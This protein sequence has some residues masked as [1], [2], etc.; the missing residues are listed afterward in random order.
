MNV[1]TN[2]WVKPDV[3]IENLIKVLRIDK[4]A[5]PYVKKLLEEPQDRSNVLLE[6]RNLLKDLHKEYVDSIGNTERLHFDQS[7]TDMATSKLN[8][9]TENLLWFL[10]DHSDETIEYYDGLFF[11]WSYIESYLNASPTLLHV[12]TV[13]KIY[14]AP[15]M[16]FLGPV[17]SSFVPIIA[18]KW[19]GL[20]ISYS[21]A[22]KIVWTGLTYQIR[23]AVNAITNGKNPLIIAA[24]GL[25][26][27][28][29]LWGIWTT[30]QTSMEKYAVLA[31]IRERI[32][33]LRNFLS[34]LKIILHDKRNKYFLNYKIIAEVDVLLEALSSNSIGKDLAIFRQLFSANRSVNNS[35]SLPVQSG[36][37]NT[38]N[39]LLVRL[40]CIIDYAREISG[41]LCIARLLRIPGYCLPSW[42]SNQT[43]VIDVRGLCHPSLNDPVPNDIRL[44]RNLLITGPNQAGKST[45]MRSLLL[46]VWMSQTIG[47]VRA[48]SFDAT[49][50]ELIYS[51]IGLTDE[52]GRESLFQAEMN[53]VYEYLNHIKEQKDLKKRHSICFFD[54]LFTSTNHEEGV[55]AALA[56]S[57][58]LEQYPNALTII[59]S[60][61]T[62]LKNL[63]FDKVCLGITTQQGED[64]LEKLKFTYK[65]QPGISHHR[66]ALKL[67]KDKGYNPT[68]V[69]KAYENLEKLFSKSTIFRDQPSVLNDQTSNFKDQTP[70]LNGQ[71]PFLKDQTSNLND[72]TSNFKDQT[73]NFKDQTSNF[74]D[75]T[76][77]FK[78]Q[79]S[80]L[81]DQ[82][83]NFKDQT[84]SITPKP[85]QTISPKQIPKSEVADS[86]DIKINNGEINS[87]KAA[88][89]VRDHSQENVRAKKDGRQIKHSN[90]SSVV[91]LRQNTFPVESEQNTTNLQDSYEVANKDTL[92]DMQQH[93]TESEY[94]LI[95]EM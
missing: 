71:T 4:I 83:S 14:L 29:Y 34:D 56:V 23:T 35:K 82:T 30:I 66:V 39:E 45:F 51:Y 93:D 58:T 88:K 95:K 75:Q 31:E 11:T 74:K 70:F 27:A 21:M 62:E 17:I 49:P 12:S 18:M 64:L 40:E 24:V 61:F 13:S 19:Y 68:L 73:S 69:S 77:N 32:R 54:E 26:L 55:S 94:E 6:R 72:Q 57:S 81:K 78:D 10:S 63:N 91:E 84:L 47:V 44:T 41:N 90:I 28:F 7:F 43:P 65:V 80:V 15:L 50:F 87:Q 9:H 89:I 76:S 1:K 3:N 42:Y 53:A 2:K 25:Y 36:G 85:L 52:I 92:Y 37:S 5:I 46:A 59:S 22:F 86:Q 48:N 16:T 60:H 79:T 38:K 67:M 20:D 33:N 8:I